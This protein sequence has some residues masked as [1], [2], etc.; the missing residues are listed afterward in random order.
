M[1]INANKHCNDD[2]DCQ[3]RTGSMNIIQAGV[4]KTFFQYRFTSEMYLHFKV[5]SAL[6]TIRSR[7]HVQTQGYVR[8]HIT[9]VLGP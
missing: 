9:I 4:Q 2:D 1:Y 8:N 5:V 6:E 3:P 7:R